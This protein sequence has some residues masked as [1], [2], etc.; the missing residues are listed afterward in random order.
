MAH[1]GQYQCQRGCKEKFKT[2]SILDE[3]HKSKHTTNTK[4]TFELKCN[5]CNSIFTSQ[6]H[7]RQHV[8]IK[9]ARQNTPQQVNCEFCGLI[10]KN[11]VDLRKHIEICTEGFQQV[12][13]KVCKYFANGG[14]SKGQYCR[15]AHPQEKDFSSTP[16]CRNGNRCRFFANGTCFFFHRGV[17]VQKPRNQEPFNGRNSRNEIQ[18][19]AWCKFLEDCVRVPNC[20]F[21]HAE[22]DFP[23]LPKSNHPP[24]E[25]KV[26]GWWADY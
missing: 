13:N 5:V 3:H 15:F 21:L 7:L 4:Q 22:E 8:D 16:H 17:G 6:H 2:F 12:G 25:R 24:S 10:V 1:E 23:Q 9:H 20:P 19:R 14:C 18:P 26:E 11:Q